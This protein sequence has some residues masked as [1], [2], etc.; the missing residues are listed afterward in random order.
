[1]FYNI[2][3]DVNGEHL[4]FVDKNVLADYSNQVS[5]LLAK[6]NNNATLVFNGFPGGA[7]SFELVTRFCYNN[8]TIDITPSNIFLLHS[9]G[10]FMEITTLIKQT[11]LYLEG[12]H[13][14]T[15]S[16]FIN[17][18][19]QCHIL[20]PF[21]NNSPVFQDFLNTLLGNLTVPS[22]ESSSCPSSSN[23]SSFLF[24]S[25]D[26]STKGS[27]SNT[28]VDYWKFDDLSFLNLDLFQNLIK[29]M[30]SLHMH[31]PRIS[32][33]IFHFQ[34]SKFF[35]C[36]SHDQKCKIAETN[37]NLLSLLNGSTFSCRSLLDAFGMSLSLNL[38]TNE[39][40]KLETFL[41]SRLDEFT[42]NDLLVRGEKKVAFD[43]D[44]VLRL[45]KH[46]L[47]ERRIN[48]LLV[49]QVKKVGLLID[50]FM[51]E[52]APDRFLKPSKFLALAMALPDISRQSHDRLYN[53]INLYLEVHRGLSEEHNTKLWSV[54]DLN[55]LSSMVKMRL[56]IAK[57]GNTRLLHFVKQ[58]H[59]KG[60]VYN[61]NRV[62]RR[63]INTTENKRQGMKASQDTPKF[64]SKKSRMLDPC[65][66]KSL[67]RLC[68]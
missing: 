50:L 6:T 27:R 15:W 11:E 26:N 65:N 60:R 14:W 23:S 53:A 59:V 19:K 66:A 56:N 44:L 7:E 33:F 8:G 61:G 2:Q 18:L 22:Y 9:G 4:F 20:Y 36:S 67:P 41:G 68:H 31:H 29:S 39:R 63:V 16:E 58:N 37:I 1:M 48:G 57:N 38:R 3:V 43:V 30:I 10:T 25:S 35:L 62:S 52:V 45:I 55:K 12:I 17:G 5:K 54:L 28:F 34:K 51:L 24:S 13:C 21:M 32:S 47:L 42:I 40:S 46:F 64:V 49:H